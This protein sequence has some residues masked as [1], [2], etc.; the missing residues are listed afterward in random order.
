LEFPTVDEYGVAAFT[1]NLGG[2]STNGEKVGC[3]VAINGSAAGLTPT[4]LLIT[5]KVTGEPAYVEVID[6]PALS[7]D[8]EVDF[9]VGK[10]SNPSA[11]RVNLK[12]GVLTYDHTGSTGTKAYKNY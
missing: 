2:Y 8:D 9:M 1:S 5:S 12:I 4:C 3:Y 10:I 7:A 11:T 6:L